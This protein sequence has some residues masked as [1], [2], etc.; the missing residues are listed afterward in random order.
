MKKGMWLFL[1]T[2]SLWEKTGCARVQRIEREW[3]KALEAYKD[4]KRYADKGETIGLE[5]QLFGKNGF[6][7][8]EPAIGLDINE[9]YT[10]YQWTRK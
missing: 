4:A 8:W 10:I 2:T 6:D 7:E 5:R 3:K 1:I 9:N